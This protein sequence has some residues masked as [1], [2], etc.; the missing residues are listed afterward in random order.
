MEYG[1]PRCLRVFTKDLRP[2]QVLELRR[3]MLCSET[4]RIYMLGLGKVVVSGSFDPS[5]LTATVVKA[6]YKGAHI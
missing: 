1:R 4:G 3:M 2:I 6:A 5:T